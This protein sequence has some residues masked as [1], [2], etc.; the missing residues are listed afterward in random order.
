MTSHTQSPRHRNSR[1]RARQN[2][3][4][5]LAAAERI[6]YQQALARL[7]CWWSVS[8]KLSFHYT[9]GTAASALTRLCE[10]ANSGFGASAQLRAL[11]AQ[12]TKL[13]EVATGFCVLSLRAR[14]DAARA[15]VRACADAL[16]TELRSELAD[17]GPCGESA[18]DITLMISSPGA[19]ELCPQH[20]FNTD[21]M[22]FYRDWGNWKSHFNVVLS[23]EPTPELMDI[24][25]LHLKDGCYLIPE[26]VGLVDLRQDEDL[27]QDEERW[28]TSDDENGD[29][30]FDTFNGDDPWHELEARIDYGINLT[31]SEST[32][33]DLSFAEFAASFVAVTWEPE[34][35]TTA[36]SDH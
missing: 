30:E 27:C 25:R 35:V 5:E 4:R 18:S 28:Q 29:V 34:A 13:S 15:D 1:N 17:P 16:I 6:S 31:T 12:E 14:A 2:A 20:Y 32:W 21:V 11:D 24:L 26:Q 9:Q 36:R 23:G 7:D 22:Y 8:V 3:A 19:Y 10:R 33:T